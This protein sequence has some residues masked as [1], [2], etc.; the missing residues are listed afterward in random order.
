MPTPNT[1]ASGSILKQSLDLKLREENGVPRIAGQEKGQ[2][3]S[4]GINSSK[5]NVSNS[6]SVLCGKHLGKS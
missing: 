3:F 4:E 6:G 5:V 1:L 2:S